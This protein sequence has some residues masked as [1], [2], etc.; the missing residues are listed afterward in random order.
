MKFTSA[1]I[2]SVSVLLASM[3]L[4]YS[5]PVSTSLST[6][7][8]GKALTGQR[9]NTATRALSDVSIQIFDGRCLSVDAASSDHVEEADIRAVST[10]SLN[11]DR[12]IFEDRTAISFAKC[13][14]SKGQK[15]DVITKGLHNDQA[16]N[17]LIVS[18]AVC[19]D[20]SD[21]E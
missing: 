4:A 15:F 16:G 3:Q 17:S 19:R 10:A 11:K 5:A 21:T 9:D 18:T 12:D 6:R 13:D 20:M 2:A 8:A 7:A 1:T 14:G